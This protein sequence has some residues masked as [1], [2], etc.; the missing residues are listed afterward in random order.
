MLN[1]RICTN[2]VR[3]SPWLPLLILLGLSG[4]TNIPL[5]NFRRSPAQVKQDSIARLFYVKKSGKEEFGTG[6]FIQS[7]PGTC[8]LLTVAH[9]VAA[10]YRSDIEIGSGSKEPFGFNLV[11]K[12]NLKIQTPNNKNWEASN[13]QILPKLDLAIVSF[14]AGQETCPYTAV[15]FGN[16]DNVEATKK[17]YIAGYRAG[18]D[19]PES[20]I[21]SGAITSVLNV[22]LDRGYKFSHNAGLL[23]G[24]IGAPILNEEGK[25]IG[26]NGLDETEILKLQHLSIQ[27]VSSTKNSAVHQ[28][29]TNSVDSDSTIRWAIPIRKYQENTPE[30]SLTPT[31]PTAKEWSSWGDAFLSQDN[32]TLSYFFALHAFEKAIKL[33]PKDAWPWRQKAMINIIHLKKYKEGLIAAE[34]AIGLDPQNPTIIRTHA[35]S[36]TLLGRY[37]EAI[38]SVKKAV[39]NDPNYFPGWLM[40]SELLINQNQCKEAV[41]SLE[42][43]LTL[44]SKDADAWRIKAQFSYDCSAELSKALNAINQSLKIAPDYVPSLLVKGRI[45]GELGR[46]NECLSLLDKTL[47]IDSSSATWYVKSY[48]LRSMNRYEEAIKAADKAINL[49]TTNEEAIFAWQEKVAGLTLI[50]RYSQ[51]LKGIEKVTSIASKNSQNIDAFL[52][53]KG[54]ILIQMGRRQ[55]GL[56]IIDETIEKLA[57]SKHSMSKKQQESLQLFQNFRNQL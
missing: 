8:A 17:I 57:G 2:S 16:S 44:N 33:N 13:V 23:S 12:I 18:T 50:G 41:N 7:P 24:M 5:W 45:L 54:I 29:K 55:E 1:F 56:N 52:G 26:I 51:A 48:C 28:E 25:V 53:F 49:A 21:V 9:L 40:L 34:K 38:S 15:E 3:I 14:K 32:L 43:V 37:K 22:S 39:K 42:R 20:H 46:G 11:R 31:P 30:I 47:T 6:F 19:R 10:S 36:L 27:S 4:C 35:L